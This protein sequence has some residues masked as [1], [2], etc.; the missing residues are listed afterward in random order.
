MRGERLETKEA[1][2]IDNHSQLHADPTSIISGDHAAALKIQLNTKA[3][4]VALQCMLI[5]FS[6]F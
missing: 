2:G 1:G 3:N 6:C 5:S 4:T